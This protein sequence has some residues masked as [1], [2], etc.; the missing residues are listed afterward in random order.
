MHDIQD[1]TNN[2]LERIEYINT[3]IQSASGFEKPHEVTANF[4]RMCFEGTENRAVIINALNGNDLTTTSLRKELADLWGTY[5]ELIS[6][7]KDTMQQTSN[8][9]PEQLNRDIEKKIQGLQ[10]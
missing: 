3:I 8:I 5:D 2:F 4:V 10:R 9:I 1:K 7:A 6:F